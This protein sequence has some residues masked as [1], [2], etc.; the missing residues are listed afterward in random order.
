MLVYRVL[1]ADIVVLTDM[2]PE[3]AKTVDQETAAVIDFPC[4]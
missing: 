2:M 3:Y 1:L 4:V